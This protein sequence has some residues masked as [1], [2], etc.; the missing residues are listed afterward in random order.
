LA[1]IIS[2]LNWVAWPSGAGNGQK[3]RNLWIKFQ[4]GMDL[5]A[6]DLGQATKTDFAMSFE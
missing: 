6:C 3:L 4:Q 1:I 5:L 2:I